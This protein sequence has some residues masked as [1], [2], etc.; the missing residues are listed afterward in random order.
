MKLVDRKNPT[1]PIIPPPVLDFLKKVGKTHQCIE[2]I[3]IF[4]SRARGDNRENSDVDIAIYGSLSESEQANI[5][6]QIE[7]NDISLLK[8]D[9]VFMCDLSD[10]EFMRRIENEGIEI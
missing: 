3:C 5:F 9:V 1:L 4:G 6:D 10:F 2:K 8:I 7:E